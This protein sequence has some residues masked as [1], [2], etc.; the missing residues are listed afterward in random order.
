MIEALGI[1]IWQQYVR[2]LEVRDW[3]QEEYYI[4]LVE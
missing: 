2:A 3:R 4:S 1:L